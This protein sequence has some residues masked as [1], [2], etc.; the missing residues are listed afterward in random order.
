M[1]EKQAALFFRYLE[2]EKNASVNTINAY[3]QDLVL[4]FT[5]LQD[6][7]WEDAWSRLT[8]LE[9]RAYLAYL[10]EQHFARRSIARRIMR[11]EAFIVFWCGKSVW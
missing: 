2:I 1:W 9:I 7:G 10:H 11:C 4:F 3:R 6:K 5:F 8:T